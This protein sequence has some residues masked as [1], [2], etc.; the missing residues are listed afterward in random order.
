GESEKGAGLLGVRW[1]LALVLLAAVLAVE[2]VV[3]DVLALL[4]ALQPGE[5]FYGLLGV[6]FAFLVA[7]RALVF[8]FHRSLLPAGGPLVGCVSRE[9]GNGCIVK[10]T[11]GARKGNSGQRD[12]G[13]RQT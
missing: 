13:K 12:P 11:T 6:A 2:G 3:V 1:L 9:W 4:L 10:A 5:D 8:E 7:E